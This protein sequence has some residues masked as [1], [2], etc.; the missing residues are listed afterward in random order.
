MIIKIIVFNMIGQEVREL[1]NK[2]YNSG[3]HSIFWD[4]R[5]KFGIQVPSGIYFYKISA[6]DFKQVQKMTFL[7]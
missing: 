6:G 5:D 1:I 2:K 3:N 7:Q 4:G